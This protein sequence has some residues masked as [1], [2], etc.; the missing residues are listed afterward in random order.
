MSF[1]RERIESS[2]TLRTK[3][4]I[5]RT[6]ERATTETG[7]TWRKLSLQ[8]V[9]F[10]ISINQ[11]SEDVESGTGYMRPETRGQFWRERHIW[12]LF[13][14]KELMRCKAIR[15]ESNVKGFILK[16]NHKNALAGQAGEVTLRGLGYGEEP[17]TQADRAARG[18]SRRTGGCCVLREKK[19]FQRKEGKWAL[20]L[21]QVK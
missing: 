18:L 19:G 21:S 15:S 4:Q 14:Y 11:L 8:Q 12:G 2:K 5:T 13:A 7:K 16:W 3:A 9:Q 1:I 20:P 6:T 17:Q 10:K